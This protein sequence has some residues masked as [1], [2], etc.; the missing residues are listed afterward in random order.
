MR[1]RMYK[2]LNVLGLWGWYAIIFNKLIKRVT[3]KPWVLGRVAC[4]G[5]DTYRLLNTQFPLYNFQKARVDYFYRVNS[6]E[7]EIRAKA[8]KIVRF[9]KRDDIKELIIQQQR[10]VFNF[11]TPPEFLFMD[12]YAELTDQLF[13]ACK[14]NTSFCANYSDL[15]PAFERDFISEG[16]MPSKDLKESYRQFYTL[17]RERFGMIDIIFIHFPSKL[18]SRELF[19]KRHDHIKQVINEIKDEFQPFYVYEVPDS[20]VDFPG[21]DMDKFPYHYNK[22][23]YSFL[24]EI[25]NQN[26]FKH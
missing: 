17:I 2:V 12:S 26:H 18:E 23:T 25:I 8:E 20:I 10:A 5:T 4:L 22:E 11:N 7:S 14:G 19:I 6:G 3:S 21:N 9:I 15:E 13:V 16:L 24:K 1:G